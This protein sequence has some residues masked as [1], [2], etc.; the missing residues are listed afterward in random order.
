MGEKVSLVAWMLA[1]AISVAALVISAASRSGDVAMG[2]AH[3]AVAAGVSIFFALYAIHHMQKIASAG[4]PAAAVATECTRSQGLVWTWAA[5][6]IAI[7]YGT[8]VMTWKEWIPHFGGIF[9][10]GGVCLAVAAALGKSAERG[11]SDPA[12]MNIARMLTVGQLVVMLLLIVGFLVDGQMKRFLVERYTDWP[13]KNVM[14]FGA[15]A[16][17]AIS[18]AALSIVPWSQA[19]RT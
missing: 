2:Y 18:G 15:L 8:G 14:F 9:A 1:I 17:A 7:T 11:E 19:K 3:M 13:A 5:I 16:I 12:M 4:A 10:V 6:V